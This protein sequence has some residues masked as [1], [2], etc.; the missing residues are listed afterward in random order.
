LTVQ[1][2]RIVFVIFL[3]VILVL[4]LL[5]VWPHF[6]EWGSM[7]RQ[8]DN[9]YGDIKNDNRFIEQD[10][11]P[12]NGWKMQVAKLASREGASVTEQLV[13]PEVQ[14]QNTIRVQERKTGVFVQNINPGS[15]KTNN[16][17]FEEHSTTIAVESQES[18]LV[19]FLYNM[20][21]DM[22]MIRVAKLDLKPADANRY[23]LKAGITLT[24]N[25]TKKPAVAASAVPPKRAPGVKPAGAPG[26]KPG[27]VPAPGQTA[28][29]PPGG[30][31][32][33]GA[34][35]Q[36]PPGQRLNQPPRPMRT[37]PMPGTAP[38]RNNAGKNL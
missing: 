9:M 34:N 23:R 21:N 11:N 16:P 30:P 12:S 19:A 32:A 13:D 22:A 2:R 14:F 4:N 25:Y 20:G 36:P 5:F 35:R 18:Q 10:L 15:V 38:G 31:A 6:G 8:L 24:A 33:P 3:V 28:K 1:E 17:F 7:K 27:A 29:R 26:A 37:I